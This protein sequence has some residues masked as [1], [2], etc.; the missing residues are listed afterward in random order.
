[1]ETREIAKLPIH[2]TQDIL[3]ARF[4]VRE[5]ARKLGFAAE[6]ITQLA[7]AISEICRNA[8]QYSGADCQAIIEEI[9]NEERMAIRVD[10]TDTGKGI[11]NPK[12]VME[13]SQK[14][15]GSGLAGTRAIMDDFSIQS[16]VGKGT[17][18]T[19]LKYV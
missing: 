8:V 3:V 5:E 16:T 2:K 15:L 11:E 7:T 9:K 4:V 12:E 18:V 13:Q 10:V 6:K 1:M 17:T 19:F 14:V